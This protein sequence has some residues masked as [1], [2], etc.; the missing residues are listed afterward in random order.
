MEWFVHPIVNLTVTIPQ[1]GY[2]LESAQNNT[3]IG[4][5]GTVAS[6]PLKDLDYH[7]A[8]QS[9]I[10]ILIQD[11]PMAEFKYSTNKLTTLSF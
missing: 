6:S 9:T 1:E 3:V 4:Q 8:L 5:S 11:L 7:Q 10:L 2:V